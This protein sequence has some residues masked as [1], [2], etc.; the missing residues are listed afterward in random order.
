MDKTTQKIV[1]RIAQAIRPQKVFLFGSRATGTQD[2]DS[3]IDLLVLYD[4]P[5]AARELQCDIHRLF[6][7]PGFSLDVFVLS[8][9]DYDTQKSVANTLACEVSRHGILCYG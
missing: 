6:S 2:S 3:D 1:T 4:G 5:K 8:P 9:E 7:R